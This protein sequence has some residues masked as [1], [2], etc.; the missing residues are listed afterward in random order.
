M[1]RL[2]TVGALLGLLNGLVAATAL[3]AVHESG[4]TN[5]GW[6]AYAPVGENVVYDHYWFPWEYVV[7]PV[8]LV[9]LNAVLLPVASSRGWLTLTPGAAPPPAP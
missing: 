5:V 2:V 8:V 9:V 6:F 4:S 7:V 3:Y 1:K